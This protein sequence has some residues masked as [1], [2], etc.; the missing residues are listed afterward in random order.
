MSF[1][2]RSLPQAVCLATLVVAGACSLEPARAASAPVETRPPNNTA[3]S[4]A[5]KGQTRAPGIKT[6][7]KLDVKTVAKG[8]SNPWAFEFLPDGRVLV[9][10]RSGQLRIVD[11]GGKVSEPLRGLPQVM[12][13]GQGGLLDVATDSAFAGWTSTRS[14]AMVS[15]PASRSP[16]LS[17]GNGT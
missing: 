17:E 16:A 3:F 1:Q 9:T 2:I 5:F 7:F 14:Q 10:E 12:F 8:L 11:S 13:Q 6:S 4:P 15:S